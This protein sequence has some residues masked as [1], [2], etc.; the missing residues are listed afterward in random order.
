MLVR[1][2]KYALEDLFNADETGLQYKSL[3]E[4]TLALRNETK[5]PGHKT[6]KE[7]MAAMLF[8]NASGSF[9]VPPL[10]I[11]TVQKPRCFTAD[12]ILPCE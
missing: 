6:K 1:D 2:Q 7:R 3:P 10:C 5:V 9:R 12:M 11:G 4:K 8:A